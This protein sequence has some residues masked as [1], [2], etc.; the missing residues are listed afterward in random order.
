MVGDRIHDHEAAKAWAGYGSLAAPT[1]T[2]GR[3]KA[4]VNADVLIDDRLSGSIARPAKAGDEQ[5]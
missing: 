3:L 2:P 4:L 5:V 1:A